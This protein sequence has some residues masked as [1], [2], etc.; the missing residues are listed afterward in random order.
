MQPYAAFS[1]GPLI[2]IAIENLIGRWLGGKLV[3]ALGEAQQS[4]N[5]HA[6]RK[7]SGRDIAEFCAKRPDRS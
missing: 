5:K 4:S 3:N 2:T 6:A 1:G 7:R